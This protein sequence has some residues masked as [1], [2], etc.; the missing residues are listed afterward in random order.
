[1]DGKSGSFTIRTNSMEIAGQVVQ[2][3]AVEY[4]NLPDLSSTVDFPGEIENL[5]KLITKV[6]EMQS[7]R[8]SIDADI[9][10]NSVAVR[11]LVVRSEDARLLREWYFCFYFNQCLIHIYIQF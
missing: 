2:S 5:K 3:L 6:E 9:A 10:E 4:L 8:A 7:V 1:M 11:S